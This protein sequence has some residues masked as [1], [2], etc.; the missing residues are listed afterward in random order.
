MKLILIRVRFYSFCF[1]WRCCPIFLQLSAG[2]ILN[3]LFN[4]CRSSVLICT[5]RL[6]GQS[7]KSS[8]VRLSRAPLS[9]CSSITCVLHFLMIALFFSYLSY[10]FH[11]YPF[12]NEILFVHVCRG[13]ILF[14]SHWLSRLLLL[15][16]VSQIINMIG[17]ENVFFMSPFILVEASGRKPISKLFFKL[18]DLVQRHI[19]VDFSTS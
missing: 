13:F 12:R 3:S 18:W 1:W 16:I 8:N 15:S 7:S 2:S 5:A 14:A 19:N 6:S 17:S 4:V 11:Q 10:I 9:S